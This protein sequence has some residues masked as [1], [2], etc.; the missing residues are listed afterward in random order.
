MGGRTACAPLENVRRLRRKC[1]ATRLHGPTTLSARGL[2]PPGGPFP[3]ACAV[4]T[5]YVVARF[6]FYPDPSPMTES[7]ANEW[8]YALHGERVGPRSLEEVRSLVASG[9]LDADAL[10]WT[11]G[12]R[13][14]AR[15]GDMPIV[16]PTWVPPHTEVARVPEEPVQRAEHDAPHPWRRVGARLVDMVVYAFVFALVL[17]I[18]VPD[19]ATRP[20]PDPATMNPLYHFAAIPVLVLLEGLLLHLFGATPGKALFSIRVTTADGGRLSFTQALSRTARLW[21]VGL[22]L[23]LP[24]LSLVAPIAAYFRLNGRGRTWWDESLD[25][26]VEH[27]PITLMSAMTITGFLLLFLFVLSSALATLAPK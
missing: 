7:T 2:A 15:V 16:S 1:Q 27:G 22:A 4:R 23:G 13:E 12:M 19:L 21:V 14:W 17:A 25:L 5:L 24:I 9:V 10:V 8:Y 20:P 26:R 18:L 6:S 11:T 3:L